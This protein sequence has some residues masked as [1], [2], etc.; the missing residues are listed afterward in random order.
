MSDANSKTTLTI[1]LVLFVL[2]GALPWRRTSAEPN[3]ELHI[4][5]SRPDM[6]S[7]GNALVEFT[8]PWTVRHT[9]RLNDVDVTH[10]FRPA[11]SGTSLVALLDHLTL[12][13]NKLELQDGANVQ[14]TLELF[15]HPRSGPIF[16]GP[17][18]MP[19]VCQTQDNGLGVALDDDCSAPTIV[20]YYYKST[21]VSEP[22]GQDP[23][24]AEYESI[25]NANAL[26]LPF[27]FKVLDTST[28]L[29]TDIAT[30]RLSDG[31]D[32]SF[33]IRREVGVIN[34][35]IY[36]IEF[37]HQPGQ[38]LPTPWARPTSAWNGR[39]VYAF[40]GGCGA[41]FHQG[42]LNLGEYPQFA[43]ALERGYALVTSSLNISANTCNDKISAESATMVKEHFIERY[44]V[45]VHTIGVGLSGGAAGLYLIAQ[46]YPG[47]LDGII[48]YWST[49]DIISA[50]ML[51]AS[52]CALLR[53][54]I[55]QSSHPW[56]DTQKTAVSGL[57]SW[58]A[59]LDAFGLDPK[60][61]DPSLPEQ[62]V[63]DR[64]RNPKGVRCTYFDNAINVFGRD[65]K[66]GFARRTLD[67][68]GI[69]YGLNALNAGI[70]DAEQFLELN[71]RIGGFDI[72]GKIVSRRSEG[73]PEA[74]RLAHERGAL[75]TGRSLRNVP[76]IDWTPYLDDLAN[77]HT[78][79]RAFMVR[80]RLLAAVG[81][82]D[83]HV[84]FVTPRPVYGALW[85][86]NPKRV[87]GSS[88]DE[89]V[90]AMDRWLT[91]IAADKS[92]I[93]TAEK[94]VRNKPIDVVDGCIATSGEKIRET[95]SIKNVGRCNKL[96]PVHGNP[97]V[98]A[99][100]P[101]RAEMLKCQL[102][103]V[104]LSDYESPLSDTQV[105]RLRSIFSAGVC[106]YTRSTAE[107]S[108]QP[109]LWNAL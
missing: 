5:S 46:N 30:T 54:A 107:M 3:L 19:F 48:P 52:D 13:K 75:V 39:V 70:I 40:D 18:Q 79:D 72:D 23:L 74:I 58:Q 94:I 55:A 56:T 102:K 109:I 71:E 20:Q 73:D 80:E 92:A 69:Q 60:A 9:V 57:A 11:Q 29:P 38:P 95:A 6:V 49:P 76:I 45:P 99:G 90:L 36:R 86:L 83:N 22:T 100:A 17:H 53:Q 32:V 82:A 43:T 42:L 78:R 7:A 2:A 62:I 41:G 77:S 34:R 63:Y 93:D 47:I 1:S 33:I 88:L 26:S 25:A 98:G 24:I 27:G 35:A 16:S 21:D 105:E 14:V 44:G 84:I 104:D 10:F 37:I 101:H 106:D 66:S 8:A 91:R 15:N 61:C 67:N 12:G 103:N 108:P 87:P 51:A 85:A 81:N 31:S 50:A 28:P 68:V 64:V 97:R 89:L 96:Y 65:Q 59:C 4:L